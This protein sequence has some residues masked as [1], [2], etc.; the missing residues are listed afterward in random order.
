[1]VDSQ[2]PLAANLRG[3]RRRAGLSLTELARR[4]GLG[5]ATLTQLE[6]GGGNPTL[7]TLYALADEL[8][9]AL[10]DLLTESADSTE[11][12]VVRFGQ[13]QQVRGQVVHAWL[14]HRGRL[15]EVTVELYAVTLSGA[16]RQVSRPHP[17]G[18]REHLYLHAGRARVGRA[19]QPLEL[20][21]GDYVDFA[22]DVAHSYQCLDVTPALGTLF[23]TTPC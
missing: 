8:G 14:L 9:V 10:A 6:A 3:Y 19:E 11:P 5:R 23:I 20:D 15:P 16:A 12:R 21:A 18:T 17:S 2:R 13:G 1:M 22:A 7:E 4:A